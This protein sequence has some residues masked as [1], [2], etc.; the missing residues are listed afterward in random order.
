MT[1]RSYSRLL[2][3]F[4]LQ[5]KKRIKFNWRTKLRL[6]NCESRMMVQKWR[7]FVVHG[8]KVVVVA[9]DYYDDDEEEKLVF[10][11][12]ASLF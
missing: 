5:K 1:E 12:L 10:S 11:F 8:R 6:S 7:R 3:G 9:S 2:S 4:I